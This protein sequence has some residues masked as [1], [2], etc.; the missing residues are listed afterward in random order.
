MTIQE[1]IGLRIKNLRISLDYSQTELAH[2]VGYKDKTSIAKIEAGKIDL[3]QSKIIALANALQT[4]PTYLIGDAEPSEQE[5]KPQIDTLAA[6]FD[7]QNFTKDE[8]NE[9]INF[10][11][12]VKNKRKSEKER[13]TKYSELL[14]NAAHERTD[15]DVTDEMRKHDDDIMDDENF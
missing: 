10:V 14:P 2:M 3:P 13:L 9:I 7:A 1:K 4:T 6:H 5:I 15:I 8:L 11:E 12:F